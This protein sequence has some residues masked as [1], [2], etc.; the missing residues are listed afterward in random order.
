MGERVLGFCHSF[1]DKEK[2]PIGYAFDNEEGLKG[3]FCVIAAAIE[4]SPSNYFSKYTDLI[5]ISLS[6][7][8]DWDLEI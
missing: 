8:K 2:Y 7:S 5:S 3:N 4:N 1:L 6:L